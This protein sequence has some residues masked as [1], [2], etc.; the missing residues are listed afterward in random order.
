MS[1]QT[2]FQDEWQEEEKFLS[3]V[4]GVLHDN[5]KTNVKFVEVAPSC[6]TWEKDSN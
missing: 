5:K 1:N 4:A 3:W 6:L 2:Y